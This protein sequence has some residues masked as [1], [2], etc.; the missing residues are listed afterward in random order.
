M[1]NPAKR[2]DLMFSDNNFRESGALENRIR[3]FSVN[4][5]SVSI[6]KNYDAG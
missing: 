6:I 2:L 3:M 1:W 4:T 5:V